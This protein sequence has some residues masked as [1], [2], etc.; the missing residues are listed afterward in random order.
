MPSLKR[1]EQKDLAEYFHHQ[2]QQEWSSNEQQDTN[3]YVGNLLA[4][5]SRSE[6]L[7]CH[8]QSQL[9]LQPLVTLYEQAQQ[10]PDKQ[11]R[12][13]L[14]RQLGDQA[15]FIAALF[16]GHY[17][18]KGIGRDYLIGM[19]SAAYDYLASHPLPLS[20]VFA[21][22]VERFT[23]VLDVIA[24]TCHRNRSYNATE[25]MEL[26]KHWKATGDSNLALQLS[27]MGVTLDIPQQKPH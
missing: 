4:R 16:P 18:R 17:A 6:Q 1:L 27:A 11:H 9:V 21:D 25:I 14:L 3:W 2:L 22:L 15:L 10:C 5:F 26:Y 19:G 24:R 23:A 12:C 20:H 8:Q 7:F 13:L